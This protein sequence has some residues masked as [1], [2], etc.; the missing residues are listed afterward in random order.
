MELGKPNEFGERKE[1]IGL[2]CNFS[3]YCRMF[4]KFDS[5]QYQALWG[6]Q[7]KAPVIRIVGH[8]TF[9]SETFLKLNCEAVSTK[10][11]PKDM[12]VFRT[13]YLKALDS[14]YPSTID[15]L[16]LELSSWCATIN[17]PAFL[18][19]TTTA[20]A[21]E[22]IGNIVKVVMAGLQLASQVKLLT[23]DLLLLHFTEGLDFHPS[24]LLPLLKAMAMIKGIEN[25]FQHKAMTLALAAPMMKRLV[26]SQLAVLW[27]DI[28][29]RLEKQPKLVHALGIA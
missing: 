5:K 23:D 26:Q 27:R 8:L 14:K 7:K 1:F 2:A 29:A 21:A 10:V 12:R 18:D 25:E 17:S 22:H 4:K 11:D 19:F 28:W 20:L 6:L 13:E 15:G 3:L 16:Y 9:R 24:L